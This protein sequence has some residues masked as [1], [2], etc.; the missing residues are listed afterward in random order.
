MGWT[1]ERIAESLATVTKREGYT[2]GARMVEDDVKTVEGRWKTEAAADIAEAK[3]MLL[4]RLELEYAEAWAAFER[5]KEPQVETSERRVEHLGGAELDTEE[6][7]RRG[8]TA[9]RTETQTRTAHRLPSHQFLERLTAIN[10][11]FARV[12]GLYAAPKVPQEPEDSPRTQPPPKLD[13]SPIDYREV[14]AILDR[15]IAGDHG[16]DEADSEWLDRTKW[17]APDTSRTGAGGLSHTK[18]GGQLH[19]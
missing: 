8:P 11:Q 15:L 14:N 13:P 4:A 5:S 19:L 7:G 6:P 10:D 2:I 3:G 18:L 17:V 1:C 9:G 12:L 16:P